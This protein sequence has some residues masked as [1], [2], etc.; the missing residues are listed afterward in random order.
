MKKIFKEIIILTICTST[1]ICAALFVNRFVIVNAQVVSSSM[2][3]TIS[4]DNRV[5]GLR[6][7]FVFTPHTRGDI[8]VFASPI[9]HEF[10]EAFIKRIIALPGET[11]EIINGQVLINGELLT[12]SYITEPVQHDLT[13]TLVPDGHLF[14]MGDN[15][16]NSRDSREF[17][18]IPIDSVIGRIFLY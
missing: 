6:S 14:V 15:R 4:V 10:S 2:E 11:I 12:E 16:N 3:G 18:T 5:F 7:G 13:L 9:P 17:G 1:S 8:I